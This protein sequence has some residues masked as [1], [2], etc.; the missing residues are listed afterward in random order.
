MSGHRREGRNVEAGERARRAFGEMGERVFL[1]TG[2]GWIAG[3]SLH[4]LVFIFSGI[5]WM[6]EER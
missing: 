2:D 4:F 6:L 3:E 1:C 5:G